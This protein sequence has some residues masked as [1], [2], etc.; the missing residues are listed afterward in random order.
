[1]KKLLAIL[2]AA[3]LLLG[4]AACNLGSKDKEE[5]TDLILGAWALYAYEEN[6]GITDF[7]PDDFNNGH[8][9]IFEEDRT[10]IG[11]LESDA[12]SGTW[13]RT[14]DTYELIE[15]SYGETLN[16]RIEDDVTIFISGYGERTYVGKRSEAEPGIMTLVT[17]FGGEDGRKEYPVEYDDYEGDGYSVWEMAMG[18]SEL[19]GLDFTLL[20]VSPVGGAGFIITWSPESSLFGMGDREQNEE[21]QFFDYDS[22]AWFMLDSLWQT[23]RKNI[24]AATEEDIFY[25]MEGGKALVLENLSPPMDFTLE[26]PYMG[27]AFYFAHQDGRGDIIDDINPADIDP[28]DVHWAGEYGSEIGKLNIVNYNG[29]SFRFT[30]DNVNDREEGVAALDPENPLEASYARFNFHFNMSDES[31]VVLDEDDIFYGTYISTANAVG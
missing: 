26:T 18:L 6:G 4:L 13:K 23:I 27:S 3:V 5:D 29:R 2:M 14:G 21:F 25:A 17:D 22:M 16:A 28:A 24:P 20:E 12:W 15:P 1:M 10:F 8:V 11:A 19:T 31:V 30:L 7:E 9:F